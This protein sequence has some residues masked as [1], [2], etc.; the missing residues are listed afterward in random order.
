MLN[1][2]SNYAKMKKT[3]KMTLL[4]I[5]S[6]IGILLVI[7]ISFLNSSPQFG[8]KSTGK[9]AVNIQ[10][11]PNYE[12]GKFQNVE[13]TVIMKKMD[14][15]TFPDYFTSRG[16]KIPDWSIP[17]KKIDPNYFDNQQDSLTKVTWFGHSALLLE[18]DGRKIFLDPM[19]GN[20]PAP[21]PLLGSKRFNNTLPLA[22]D[23]L[24]QLDAVLI[25]H[26]HYDHLDY[27][28]IIKIKGKVNQFYV[29]LG[30]GAHL[31]SWG[32]EKDKI[33]ELDW[34]DKASFE[35]LTLVS[36]PARHFSGRGL[37]DRYSTLWC[38]WVIQGKDDNIFFGGDS[39]YDPTFKKIGN[40]YGPF[41]FTMLDCGQYDEQ[42]P[43][44]HMMPEE[45]VQANIDLKGKL[46][47]PIHWGSFK[48]ALHSWTE[49]I[50]RLLKKAREVNVNVTTPKIGEPII[51]S[52]QEPSS[53]WWE[54]KNTANN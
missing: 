34:W 25:S 20:V 42:W 23:L 54:N 38:S 36:T 32:V 4:I 29:P 5:A 50:E 33:I 12:D 19:L 14:Y 37:F 48:I 43:E 24:P 9:N 22:I 16:N 3:L 26:D 40:I 7:G 51:I 45:V 53:N 6:L 21:H 15:S 1:V 46:L 52:E 41:D 13:E 17:V 8:A 31:T 47:M 11:S 35:G 44:I 27:E 49:P 30:I 39:G 2:S 18:I 28:S 10:K